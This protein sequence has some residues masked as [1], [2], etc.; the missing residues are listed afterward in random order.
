[1]NIR[2]PLIVSMLAIGAM[3]AVAGWGWTAIP[4]HA[5]MAV[6]WGIDGRPNGYMPRTIGL[7]MLPCV[8]VFLSALFAILPRIEPR[9][10]NLQSSRKLYL[11]GWYGTLGL[12]VVTQTLMV[13]NAAG[14][15]IDVVRSVLFALAILFIVLGN[16]MGKSRSNFFVGLRLPWTLSSELAWNTGNRLAGFGLVATG[17]ATL[18]A[19]VFVGTIFVVVVVSLIGVT[20]SFIGG[21]V[22]SYVYWKRDANRGNGDSIHE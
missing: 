9:R 5:Q 22:V 17:F 7:L 11:A 18:F 13:L 8:N 4:T 14:A 21:G 10:A 3:L 6:H 1:M 19:L 16:Y 20:L 12:G 15:H 2:T